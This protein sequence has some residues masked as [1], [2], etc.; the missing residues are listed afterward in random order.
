MPAS[1]K[2]T[3]LVIALV[4]TSN[5]EAQAKAGAALYQ[6]NIEKT[7]VADRRPIG[8]ELSDS[9][10]GEV[11]GGLWG[12]TELGLLFLNMFF[13]PEDVR[14]QPLGE[15][16]LST[17]EEEAIKRGCRRAVLTIHQF[18]RHS[19]SFGSGRARSISLTAVR[20][21][22]VNQESLLLASFLG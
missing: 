7:G 4:D 6:Y 11:L 12:Q 20:R 14:G 22:R 21:P 18:S 10:S 2:N 9:I 13:L 17:I 16:P 1:D 3:K 19:Q 8:A 15:R 5:E